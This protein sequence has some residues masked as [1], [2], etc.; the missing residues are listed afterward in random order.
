M[1]DLFG[2]PQQKDFHSLALIVGLKYIV[3]SAL[4]G[5]PELTKNISSDGLKQTTNSVIGKNPASF[6]DLSGPLLGPEAT[7]L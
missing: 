7:P 3:F 5:N 4:F 1:S 6:G 2:I